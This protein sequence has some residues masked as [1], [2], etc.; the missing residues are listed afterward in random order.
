M[1]KGDS[2]RFSYLFVLLLLRNPINVSLQE[3]S[4]KLQKVHL[5]SFLPDL[6]GKYE[7]RIFSPENRR[8][9]IGLFP[10]RSLSFLWSRAVDPD[11]YQIYAMSG[12]I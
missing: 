2:L 1:K 9:R 10:L 8:S 11:A 5:Y 12:V 7:I 3:T 4:Q 6:P